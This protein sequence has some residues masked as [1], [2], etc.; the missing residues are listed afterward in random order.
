MPF[1]KS[2]RE[3]TKMS[4]RVARHVSYSFENSHISMHRDDDVRLDEKSVA[5]RLHQ[6]NE[7]FSAI[8]MTS[9]VSTTP[10]CDHPKMS[11]F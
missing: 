4:S 6:V 2:V 10:S 9:N 7:R 11:V 3:L 1:T 5:R 8:N